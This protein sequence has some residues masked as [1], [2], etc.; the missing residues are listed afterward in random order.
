MRDEATEV[1]A[2][3]HDF[4]NGA[5]PRSL[6]IRMGWRP[7]RVRETLTDPSYAGYVVRRGERFEA[8]ASVVRLIDRD[9]FEN[10]QSLLKGP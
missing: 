5:S 1:A 9:T 2:L 7:L 3:F 6:Y 10:V 4:L 8:H